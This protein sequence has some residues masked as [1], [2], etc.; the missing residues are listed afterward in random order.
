VRHVIT[1]MIIPNRQ[2]KWRDGMVSFGGAILAGLALPAAILLIGL[3]IA[4]LTRGIIAA[5]AWFAGSP[6][7]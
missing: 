5:M 4:F 3:P 2:H 6:T 7:L 1:E